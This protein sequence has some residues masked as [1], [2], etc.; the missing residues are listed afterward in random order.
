MSLIPLPGGVATTDGDARDFIA[1]V[2]GT[3]GVE[4]AANPWRGRGYLRLS[5]HAYND[6]A[7]YERLA[8]VL[9]GLLAR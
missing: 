6:E 9:P 2:S 3:V 4:I 7:D 1:L 8:R 5:A